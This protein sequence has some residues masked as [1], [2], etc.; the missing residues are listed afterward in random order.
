[1]YD[2]LGRYG[3]EEYS[4]L[5]KSVET[6]LGD[7]G[8]DAARHGFDVTPYL[9]RFADLDGFGDILRALVRA[10]AERPEPNSRH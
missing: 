3:L 1:M 4:S 10:R 6:I 9:K 2:E 7:L 5:M 8:R